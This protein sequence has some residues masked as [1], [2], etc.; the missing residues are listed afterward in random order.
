MFDRVEDAEKLMSDNDAE[1]IKTLTFYGK[2]RYI[3][4]LYTTMQLSD[5]RKKA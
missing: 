4:F 1:N 5:L 2:E 3:V